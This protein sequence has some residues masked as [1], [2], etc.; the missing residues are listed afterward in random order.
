MSGYSL[1]MK[2]RFTDRIQDQMNAFM[3][4]G[5]RSSKFFQQLDDLYQTREVLFFYSELAMNLT[6]LCYPLR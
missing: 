5:I 4:I 2:W 1:V 3:E 6:L